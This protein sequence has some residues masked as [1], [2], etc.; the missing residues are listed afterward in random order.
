[1]N[2]RTT[3]AFIVVCAGLEAM[4]VVGAPINATCASQSLHII[5][6][7]DARPWTHSVVYN[8]KEFARRHGHSYAFASE[9]AAHPR[10]AYWSKIRLLLDELEA[11]QTDAD[12]LLWVDDDIVFTNLG[13]EMLTTW[14]ASVLSNGKA[15]S[16]SEDSAKYTVLNTGMILVK[17]GAESRQ[18]LSDLWKF[19]EGFL[20]NCPQSRCLHEQQALRNLYTFGRHGA[21][22]FYSDR[23][24]VLPQRNDAVG[25]NLNTFH[26]TSHYDACRGVQQDYEYDTPDSRWRNG[27]FTCHVTGMNIHMRS[28]LLTECLEHAHGAGAFPA[29]STLPAHPCG[30]VV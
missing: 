20:S 1:M 13:S 3:L 9:N 21:P 4:V 16:V 23:V 22:S 12:W 15:L 14:Q 5:S 6:G 2:T 29:P 18:V 25:L 11:P 26:R 10:R 7:G 27:D 19:G 17:R 24:L 30:L 8:H 28:A